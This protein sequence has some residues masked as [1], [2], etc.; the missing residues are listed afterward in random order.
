MTQILDTR[1]V[2]CGSLIFIHVNPF[3]ADLVKAL[4]F[5]F[6]HTGLTHHFLF[7]TFGHSGAQD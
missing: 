2:D 6:C 1:N 5:T 3:T 4:H 7:L